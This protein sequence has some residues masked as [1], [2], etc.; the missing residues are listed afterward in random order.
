LF[1][2]WPDGI[3]CKQF[4]VSAVLLITTI[5]IPQERNNPRVTRTFLSYTIPD[6]R[7]AYWCF[8]VCFLKSI[9]SFIL[10]NCVNYLMNRS[11]VLR[12]CFVDRCLSF[13]PFSFGH[14]VVCS[15]SIYEF[16]LP[17][18]YLQT[19]LSCSNL[20]LPLITPS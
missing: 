6:I 9:I 3:I 5:F 12:V 10:N 2:Q 11:L 20:K 14:C 13:C 1:Q 7:Q 4:I 18:W 8:S 17:L 16:W 15:S 19:L